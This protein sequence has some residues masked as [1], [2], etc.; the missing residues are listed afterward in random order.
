MHGKRVVV[1]IKQRLKNQACV[2]HRLEARN[3]M[4]RTGTEFLRKTDNRSER[5]RKV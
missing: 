4:T 5:G 3:S 1:S 2:I